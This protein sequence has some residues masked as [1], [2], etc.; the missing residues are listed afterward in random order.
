MTTARTT[1]ALALF[2]AAASPASPAAAQLASDLYTGGLAAPLY[3]A[4]PEGDD[5]LFILEK[6]GRVAV[7][8]GPG[9]AATTYLQVPGV[10]PA[11]EGGLLGLAFAPDFA[12]SGELYLN[13]TVTGSGGGN[14]LDTVIAR[15]TV[16]DPAADTAGGATPQTVLRFDQPFTN[17][18]AGW[19]GFAPGDA[20]GRFL[21]VP[22]GDGGSANDPMNNAQDPSSFLGK[23]LRLDVA[24]GDDFPSD[25]LRN[26]AV[27]GDNSG[28]DGPGLGEIVADGLRNPFRAA[29]DRQTGALYLGDVGQGEF[30]EIDVFDPALGAYDA[31]DVGGADYGWRLREGPIATPGVGGPTPPGYVDPLFSYAHGDAFLAPDTNPG[32]SVV[33]GYVYRGDLL[34]PAYEGRYFFADSTTSQVFSLDPADP[35]ATVRDETDALFPGG[36]APFGIVSFGEDSDGELY[37]VALSQGQVFAIV[38]EPTTLALAAPAAALLL[39]RRRR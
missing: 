21:Y 36:L 23:I 19:I 24:G 12:T 8:G 22:T 20:E 9:Q 7:S 17:H 38:P 15:V 13:Y 30:E 26:Y 4:S 16:P 34:G 37:V 3:A 27:P 18:N 25:P 32:A 33:G 5:R 14:P 35:F 31:G 1:A 28:V 6:G 2:A 11:A 10:N 29:F 39:R